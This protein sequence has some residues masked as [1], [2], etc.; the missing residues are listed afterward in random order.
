MENHDGDHNRELLVLLAHAQKH[1]FVS[2]KLS[3]EKNSRDDIVD[4]VLSLISYLFI[5]AHKNKDGFSKQEQDRNWDLVHE[6]SHSSSVEILATS[7]QISFA[8]VMRQ[9][10]SQGLV[11]P[12][13][14]GK[15][16]NVDDGRALT[17][18]SHHVRVA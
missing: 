17:Q 10:S 5:I 16:H 13:N 12:H 18:A 15:M 9:V 4:K 8:V 7:L 6:E 2:I 3:V 11:D 1:H 14:E